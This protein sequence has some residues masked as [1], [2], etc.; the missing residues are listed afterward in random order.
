MMALGKTAI[1][2]LTRRTDFPRAIRINSRTLRWEKHAVY[3]WLE[4]NKLSDRII[5]SGKS[6]GMRG[7]HSFTVDG[8]E[9]NE[10]PR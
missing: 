2:T 9:F 8:I 6:P 3:E 7:G 5:A 10:V 4:A 1:S